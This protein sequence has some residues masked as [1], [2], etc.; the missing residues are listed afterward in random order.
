MLFSSRQGKTRLP[1]STL[2]YLSAVVNDDQGSAMLQAPAGAFC[3]I[4]DTFSDDKRQ[5]RSRIIP[6]RSVKPALVCTSEQT[7]T[8]IPSKMLAY[9]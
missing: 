1:G 4:L 8:G 9:G 3:S 7:L 5:P 2:I 6:C